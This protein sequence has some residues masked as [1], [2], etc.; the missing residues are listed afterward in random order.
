MFDANAVI[1]KQRMSLEG[2]EEKELAWESAICRIVS[3]RNLENEKIHRHCRAF[4][5]LHVV[6]MS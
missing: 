4:S 1:L 2:L 5:S 3:V 6:Q